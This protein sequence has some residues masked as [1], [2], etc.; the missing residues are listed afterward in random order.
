M[1]PISW[2]SISQWEYDKRIWARKY[3]DGIT[4]PATP[5]MLFGKQVGEAIASNPLFLPKLP[6]GSVFEYEARATIGKVSLLGFLD[7]FSPNEPTV[8][9]YK[10]SQKDT[11]WSQKKCDNFGQISMYVLL[12]YLQDK[13]HPKDLI[14]KLSAIPVRSKNDFSME[15]NNDLPIQT[16]ET[17][18]TMSDILRF[19]KYILE[20]V[21]D[22][23]E[24]AKSYPHPHLQKK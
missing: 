21:S 19:S 8:Y 1:R 16:F 20:V 2:S 4:E 11:T 6:R 22:M 7:S 5:A 12:L 14:I 15:I 17:K 13:I 24:F 3:L 18:R 9:E 10:T 23:K